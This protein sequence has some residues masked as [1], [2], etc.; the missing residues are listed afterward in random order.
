MTV[1]F[2]AMLIALATMLAAA[3]AGAQSYPDKPI[4]LIV[5]IAAGSVTD[6]IMRAAANELAPR[7]GRE[8]VEPGAGDFFCT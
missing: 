1:L 5:S 2:R 3:P 6:V 4:R 8:H 7:L